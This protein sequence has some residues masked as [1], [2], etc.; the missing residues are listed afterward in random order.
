MEFHEVIIALYTLFVLLT[1][2]LIGDS[3]NDVVGHAIYYLGNLVFGY[4][5]FEYIMKSYW[6][7][8]DFLFGRTRVERKE[9]AKKPRINSSPLNTYWIHMLVDFEKAARL[10]VSRHLN[11]FWK[12]L[13]DLWNATPFLPLCISA[14]FAYVLYGNISTAYATCSTLAKIFFECLGV[15]VTIIPGVLIRV[16]FQYKSKEALEQPP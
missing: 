3:Q 9:K 13:I 10:M 11:D 15:F 12:E 1:F 7:W 6:E 5:W 8:M 2:V 4:V 14:L 16:L